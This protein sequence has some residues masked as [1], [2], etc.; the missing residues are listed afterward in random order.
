MHCKQY[1]SIIPKCM[2]FLTLR[3]KLSCPSLKRVTAIIESKYQS[4]IVQPLKFSGI[5]NC[6]ACSMV[7]GRNCQCLDIRLNCLDI[8]IRT[9]RNNQVKFSKRWPNQQLCNCKSSRNN[10]VLD[11]AGNSKEQKS[12]KV[13]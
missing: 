13:Q 5:F 7:F 4:T 9:F 12:D 2:G 10:N 6:C 11:D 8:E 3:E 1:G